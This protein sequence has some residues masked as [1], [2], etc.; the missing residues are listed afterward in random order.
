M[1]TSNE[2]FFLDPFAFRQFD[3]PAYKGP[4]ISGISKEDF[5]TKLNSLV[6]FT[7]DVDAMANRYTHSQHNMI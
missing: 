5:V 3:D 1:A 2:L 6:G 7:F 4:R